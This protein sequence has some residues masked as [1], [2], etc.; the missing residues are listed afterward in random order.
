MGRRVEHQGPR[1]HCLPHDENAKPATEGVL[2]S[3][4][5]QVKVSDDATE[6]PSPQSS[7]PRRGHG[8]GQ[9]R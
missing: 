8:V 9:D 2:A 1:A 3:T 7:N 6:T 4:G 5:N